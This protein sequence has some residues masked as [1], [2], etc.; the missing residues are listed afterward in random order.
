[1]REGVGGGVFARVRAHETLF[2]LPAEAPSPSRRFATGPSLS[3]K[4]RGIL[5]CGR[6]EGMRLAGKKAFIT[7]AGSGIGRATALR[8]AAEGAA[9]AAADIRRERG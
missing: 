2:R 6:R 9:V 5:V 4:G 1:M 7:G 3:R 8:F